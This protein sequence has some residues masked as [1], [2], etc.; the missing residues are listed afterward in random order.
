MK[1]RN[2][3]IVNCVTASLMY[4]W[5]LPALAEQSSSEI[6][7]VRDEYG[8]PH[9]YAN[10]TWHLFYGYGYV[11]AQDRLFQMEMARRSTQGTVAE[12]LGKD[13]VK[14]D[15][16]IRRNYWP[17]AIRAQIAALSPE[18]MSILQG[19][20][21]GMN[22]WIDK[23]NTNPETLLPKQFNTFGFTP[24]RWEP[25]D[26]AMIFV[27]TSLE[28]CQRYAALT[29]SELSMTFNF[30]HLKVDYPG[31]EKWTLAKPDFVALKTLFRHWQQGMHNVA[32]NALFWCNHD[33][34]RIISRFGD[35]GEY[36]VPA[37]KMLA[38]VLH[39]MQ[40]TPYIYQGEEI[41]MTNPHFTRITDYR[42][43][44]SLN[45]FAELRNDGRD[46]DELLAILASKSRDNSRTPMQWSNGDN[47]G[48]TAG[49]PWIGLGD[50]YQQ[51]N[52]EAALADDSS[53][54]YTYQKLI[55]LRKQE[56][57]LTWGNYQDLLPNSPVLWC[58]RREWKG[59]TLLVIAN[60][61]REIQPWQPGKMR[62]NWQLVMHNYE[63]ASPQPCAMTLR[64]FEA[65]WWL[66]K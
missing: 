23:V 38:M 3:M 42:D 22:A 20:A 54:F 57:I 15:K 55:A 65:V 61:S 1:N 25:F 28:H 52:V 19:Y 59:Q 47:A 60:L 49:E 11:V 32:W 37:A 26:V 2:R 5:S 40:G 24:K 31:G 63:E 8:M 45:M 9:I 27:G 7:I 50:N 12:V 62:G 10:D 21:D 41:G 30:H 48:F 35:E 58:Y 46:A 14:F 66:Q 13:F 18:D 6:K 64:P 29:G 44:E 16:D 56:A 51:I 17:D 33:Q 34:P 36:R 43:V 53:V 39:G 4:Y